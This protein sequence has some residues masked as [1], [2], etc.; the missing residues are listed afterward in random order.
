MI[1]YEMLLPSVEFFRNPASSVSLERGG[2]RDSFH[3]AGLRGNPLLPSWHYQLL[4]ASF[5]LFSREGRR[6]S[7]KHYPNGKP[8]S[9]EGAT[10]L[11]F[12]TQHGRGYSAQLICTCH[13][14]WRWRN[15]GSLGG[16]FLPS[17]LIHTLQ[18]QHGGSRIGICC[19]C[20]LLPY[21]CERQD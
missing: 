17:A 5:I 6:N 14:A 2:A 9:E 18:A 12:G 7:G 10:A 3:S 20:P 15:W 8:G 19:S 11:P 13:C 1:S 21:G 16:S 4:A